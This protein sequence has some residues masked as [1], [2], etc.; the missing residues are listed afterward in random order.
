MRNVKWWW[1]ALLASVSLTGCFDLDQEVTVDHNELTYKAELKLD[2]KLAAMASNKKSGGFCDDMA[3]TKADGIQIDV[4]ESMGGGDV[5]C[6]ITAKGPLEKFNNYAGSGKD[7]E[8]LV[9]ITRLEDGKFRIDSNLKNDKKASKEGMEDM[10]DAMFTGRT[11]SWRVNAPKIVESNGE[12]SDDKRHVSWR[13]PIAKAMKEQVSFYAVI[14]NEVSL[15]QSIV[16]FFAGLWH[17]FMGLFAPSSEP[18]PAP[19]VA[20]PVPMPSPAPVQEPQSAEPTTA[21]PTAP[22]QVEQQAATASASDGVGA[23]AKNADAIAPLIDP[24]TSKEVDDEPPAPAVDGQRA[25]STTSNAEPFAPSFNCAKAT[26]GQEVLICGDRELARLDVEL[27][28]LYRQAREQAADTTE[29]KKRQL[30]WLKFERG[31]CSDK[32]CLVQAYQRRMAE[33]AP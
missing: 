27:S 3:Q 28:I 22:A 23:P 2:A 9:H 21:A 14:E 20:A 12:I 32:S 30:Q 31:A 19:S 29:L 7:Q 24:K 6:T 17:R 33:L 10:L 16:D 25:V 4:K 11:M 26:A 1:M 13:V 15:W 18:A 8:T 5:I